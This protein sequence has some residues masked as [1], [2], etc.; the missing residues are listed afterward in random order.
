MIRTEIVKL[1]TILATA[2]RQK[3]KAGG[4]GI[5]I[6]RSD[7]AQ[8]GIAS[9]SKTSGKAI[10]TENTP[11]DQY[12][13]EAFEEAI[14]LTGG[15]PYRK[16]GAAKPTEPEPVP[17]MPVEE[18]AAAV[19]VIDSAEYQLIVDTYTDKNGKLSYALINKDMIRF[20]HSSSKARKMI[21]EKAS[22]EEIR[23]YVVGTKFRNLTHNPNLTDE[24]VQKMVDLL[25][26]VSPKGVLTEFNEAIR[27]ELSGK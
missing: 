7:F 15:M 21:A 17:E 6:L 4:S 3:L 14:A 24:Q 2:Y 10:P 5:V 1:T 19:V 16:R 22:V 27:R 11:A 20:M 12:P 13:A 18:E 25:D 23:M 26:E 8:P 9:I